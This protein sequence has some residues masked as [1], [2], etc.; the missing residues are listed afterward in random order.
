MNAFPQNQNTNKHKKD[1]KLIHF[2]KEILLKNVYR[3]PGTSN[4]VLKEINLKINFGEKIE[5]LEN[6]CCKSTFLDILSELIKPT[7]GQ[8]IIDQTQLENGSWGYNL[9]YVPHDIY[10]LDDTVVSILLVRIQKISM[11]I[12]LNFIKNFKF[13]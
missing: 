6:G 2:K 13:K 1:K 4:D 9:G 5:S 7:S 12:D 3:Y 10:L 8:V 11:K